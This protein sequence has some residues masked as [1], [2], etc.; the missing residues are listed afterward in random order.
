MAAI[1]QLRRGS[2]PSSLSYGEIYVNDDSASL[3]LRLSGSGDIVTLT[4]LEQKNHGNLWIDGDI[5]ASSISASGDIRIG[6]ELYLG[7]EVTDNIVIQG[8]LSSSLI[9]QSDNEFDLGSTTK[10]YKDLYVGTIHASNTVISGQANISGSEQI[11]AFGFISG[12]DL[13]SLNSYTSSN[14]TR[15]DGIDAVTSSFDTRITQLE[16]DTGS[17]DQRLDRLELETGSINTTNTAQNTRLTTLETK[18]GSL[19]TNI[20]TING[21]LGNVETTTASF[22]SRLDNLESNSG[23]SNTFQA[24]ATI[25]LNNIESTTSSFDGRLNNI[26]STTSSFDGRLDNLESTTASIDVRIGGIDTTTASLDGR[27]NVEEAKSTTLAT[28]TS[29]LDGR[30]DVEEAKSTT[31]ATVTSSFDQRLDRLQLETSSLDGRL[32]V[33]EGKSTTL[34]TVTAS[35]EG[36][37]NNVETTTSSHDD[38]IS[39]LETSTGSSDISL[40]N[41]HSFTSSFNTAITLDSTNVTVLG[42]LTVQ[43]SQTQ[44]NTQTLNI[45]DKNL[46]IASGAADSAAANGAGI[47]I[48]GASK[49]LIWDHDDSNFL[50]DARVSSSVGFVGDGS[51][52]TGVTANSVAFN[53]I[54]SKPTLLSGSKQ[55]T[56]FGFISGSDLDRLHLYTASADIRLSNLET[57]TASLDS[58]LDVEEGK[59]TTI[60]TV[61]SSFDSRLTNIESTTS[62][63]DG[64]LDNVE[65]TTSSLDTRLT[66]EESKSTTLATVTSSLD[67]RLDIEE[68]KSTTLQGVT[69]SLDSRLDN[70]ESTTSSFSGRLTNLESTTSSLDSRLDNVETIT[71]SFD[72]RLGRLQLET[73]SIDVRIDGIDTITASFDSRLDQVET[74]TGSQDNKFTNIHLTTQSL[75]SRLDNVETTTSSLVSRVDQ[76]TTFTGS[77]GT[78]AFFNVTSSIFNDTTVVPTAAAVNDAIV[79]SGGGDVTSVGAGLGLS[80]GGV[81]GDLTLALNTGSSHFINAVTANA[82]ATDISS[83]N[84]YTASNNTTNSG[85]DTRLNQLAA[86]TSSYLTSVDYTVYPVDISSDTNLAVSDTSEVNMIL[87]GD[88]LSAELIG[89]VVSGSSQT[90]AHLVNKDVNFGNGDITAS[91]VATSIIHPNVGDD[92][93]SFKTGTYLDGITEVQATR[94]IGEINATNG[95][96]SGS[97]QVVLNDADKTGFNTADVSEDSSN[98]Y[99]TDTRVKTKL[100]ADTVISGSGQV[101][102]QSAD[103]TGFTGASSITTVGTIGTGTWQ[104]TVIDKTYLDD[105]VYNT[106]LNSY[107][108]SNNVDI[109]NLESFTSSVETAI[110]LD[111]SNVTILGNLTVQGS[112]TELDVTT[113]NVADKNIL[114]ASGASDSAAADGAGITIGGANESLFWDHSSSHFTFSDDLHVV[115]NITLSGTVDG[116]DISAI[117]TDDV[118][119]ATNKYYTDARVKTKLDAETVISG[120]SQVLGI[121]SSLNT[122]TSSND[123]TNNTQND[124]LNQLSTETGSIT[125]EQAL[126]DTR[127]NQ[128]A[129]ATSSYL[130]SVDISSD[131]N[132]AVSDTNEVNMIL[133]GDTLSAEL[134]G[135]VVSGSSQITIGGDATGSA[136]DINVIAINGVA[137]SNAEASQLANIN[138]VTISNTQ[139]GYLGSSNQGIATSDTVQFAKVGV[140]GASDATYELK[141]TGDVG[142]TGD[143]V[144]YISSDKRLKD[145][146][147]PIEGALDKVSQISGNTFDWNEE[148]QNIYKGKD[149]GVIAQEIQEVMPEL[150][151][152]RDNGY[153][154]VK[155]DKIVPLLIESIKELKKEIEELKSK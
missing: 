80:G 90:V 12:S 42:N 21:R 19:D 113:L 33:E 73:A 131:T 93:I 64:R 109:T 106:S 127:L 141:V 15:I 77:V 46:L 2:S 3:V 63:L 129:A 25:Q 14:N 121:L 130:T 150:V 81:S 98:L 78:A 55:I 126:Q 49:S 18:T 102:L 16:T 28:V 29:S 43:G 8:S 82:G 20:T 17:Q 53:S 31:L 87:T 36:R 125:T 48:D 99:Y 70:V 11:T 137:I 88:T 1:I 136:N 27:L 83:L 85:Q 143:I 124:R 4:K 79:S 52:L 41:V 38:R 144:A 26:E 72:Q 30:L 24:D 147:Q 84:S 75:D 58:R 132:L 107:T 39:N 51:G 110:A 146:I 112:T 155:Y 120:S 104:G 59:S 123:T 116:I 145:N 117:D 66:R 140:G 133:T 23:S 148:K 118:S 54:T 50:F 35:L 153:L 119:E 67:S 151:D 108:A 69:S 61:T 47:T 65:S 9:P 45:E 105:E 32:D 60:Q 71:S 122:Y 101:V 142:A 154:A 115:G 57:T 95:V 135:G 114:I 68:A 149:Y 103:K 134:I 6:G 92:T 56:D 62:S 94:F 34:Q 138:S 96:V 10:K 128:L 97:Q 139:W 152:T 89:G 44:L 13:N 86:A 7:D 100:D 37:L 5:T 76:L 74:F 111:S 91:V 40:T 22:D